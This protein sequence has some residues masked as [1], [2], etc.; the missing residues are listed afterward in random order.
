[1]GLLPERWFRD[2]TDKRIRRGS[3]FHSVEQLITAINDYI[4]AHNAQPNAFTWTAKAETIM[5]K[6]RR[7]RKALNKMQSA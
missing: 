2:I 1:M 7:A 5:E 3:S 6:M 4:A